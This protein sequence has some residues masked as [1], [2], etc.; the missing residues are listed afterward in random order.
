M[1]TSAAERIFGLTLG[2][3]DTPQVGSLRDDPAYKFYR[4]TFKGLVLQP[5]A[6]S[7]AVDNPVVTIARNNVREGDLLIGMDV[8]RELHIYFAFAENKMYVSLASGVASTTDSAPAE[9]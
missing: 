5:A 6:G 2:D 1:G 7:V 3:T 4:H 8:L 9:P